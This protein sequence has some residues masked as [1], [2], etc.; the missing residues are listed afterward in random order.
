MGTEF[1]EG[2]RG[3]LVGAFEEAFDEA[4]ELVTGKPSGMHVQLAENAGYNPETFYDKLSIYP[5]ENGNGGYTRPDMPESMKELVSLKGFIEQ[6][7][8]NRDWPTATDEARQ[9]SQE[10]IDM[11]QKKFEDETNKVIREGSVG[12]VIQYSA[13]HPTEPLTC[14]DQFQKG[15]DMQSPSAATY[16]AP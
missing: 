11:A 14:W 15:A 9:Q 7:K 6:E 13:A 10:N 5:Y 8:F 4:K 1:L 16:C 3:T 2:M 12:E